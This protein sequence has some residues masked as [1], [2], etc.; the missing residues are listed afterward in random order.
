MSKGDIRWVVAGSLVAIAGGALVALR[1]G[2]HSHF[3]AADVAESDRFAGFSTRPFSNTPQPPP[4]PETPEQA[5]H[6]VEDA[7]MRWRAAILT[8]DAATVIALD[9]DFR[10]RPARYREALEKSARSDENERVRAFSTRVLGKL[11][12]AGEAT[13][14]QQLLAD[15][16]PY[17]RQNAAWGLGEL[18]GAGAVA[19]AEL[20]RARSKDTAEAVRLAARD[21]LGKVE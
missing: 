16:S 21:A 19:A 5:A 17:V 18:G 9:M 10:S 2:S 13:L 6:Q 11:K 12:N 15:A 4:P 8:K 7:M 3:R 14:F 1:H 20:R